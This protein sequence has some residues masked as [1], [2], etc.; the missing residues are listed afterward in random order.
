M[1]FGEMWTET[2]RKTTKSR[3]KITTERDDGRPTL[4][5]RWSRTRHRVVGER[6]RGDRLVLSGQF[7]AW[8]DYTILRVRV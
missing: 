6:K 1:H 7:N 3:I 4:A 5:W 2:V 8:L